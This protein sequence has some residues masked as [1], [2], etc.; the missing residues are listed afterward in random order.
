MMNIDYSYEVSFS[1][2]FSC[3]LLLC[4]V[5]TPVYLLFL[6]INVYIY[7]DGGNLEHNFIHL[8]YYISLNFDILLIISMI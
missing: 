8:S 2:V 5:C 7:V 1:T 3:V 4:V 6:K